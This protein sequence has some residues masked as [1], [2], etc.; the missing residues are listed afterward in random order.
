[1][2]RKRHASRPHQRFI[3][4]DAGARDL[5]L[6][7]HHRREMWE[8]LGVRK[9]LVLDEA[10]RVYAKWVKSGFRNGRLLG[11]IAETKE[12]V[13]AGSGCIW[14]RPAQPRPNLNVQIQPYL[15][16]IYTE[17]PFRRKGVASRVVKEAI[18]W[19]N[20]NGYS[21]LALHASRYGRGLYRKHGFTRSWEMRLELERK[22]RH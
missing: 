19:C 4:R 14:L 5:D 2:K 20:K 16:S 7:V 6:L 13:L 17:P 22:A 18:K 9:K 15:L 11:W 8:D 12:G 3:L 10:D 21:R 1:M